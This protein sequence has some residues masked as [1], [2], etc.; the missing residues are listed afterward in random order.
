MPAG[1]TFRAYGDGAAT[2]VWSI[3]WIVFWGVMIYNTLRITG[4]FDRFKQ[5]LIVQATADIR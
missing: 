1:D 2:G 3:G 5:W 4:A